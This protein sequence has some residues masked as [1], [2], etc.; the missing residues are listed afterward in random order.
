MLVVVDQSLWTAYESKLK[1]QG[2]LVD[3]TDR[4][5]LNT[6]EKLPIYV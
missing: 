2:S 1:G 5:S 6:D 3:G 4:L